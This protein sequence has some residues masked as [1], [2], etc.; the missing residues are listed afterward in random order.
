MPPYHHV[1]GGP[2]IDGHRPGPDPPASFTLLAAVFLTDQRASRSGNLWVWPGSHLDHQRLFLDRGTDALKA[3]GGH[4]TLLHPP[5]Q[6]SAPVEVKGG[7]GDLLLAHFLLGHNKGGN[8]GRRC[9]GRSTTG[10]Q[11][12]A[13]PSDGR[14]RSSTRGPS[15]SPC[16]G[17]WPPE[18]GVLVMSEIADRY[19]RRAD[20]FERLIAGVRPEQWSNPSPCEKWTAVDVVDHVVG[21]HGIM[22]RPAGR[23]PSPAP[24]ARA[25]TRWPPSAPLGPTWRRCSTIPTSSVSRPR[26]RPDP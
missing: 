25:T 18:E 7:R 5:V 4:A 17:R 26:P 2:H 14:R 13:M 1:P 9:G 21:M 15:T 10:S 11:S 24:A 22:L 12:P 8:A 16:K 3:T 20:A 6:L 19:R 23:E